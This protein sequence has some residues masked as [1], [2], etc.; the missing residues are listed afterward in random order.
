MWKRAEFL[1]GEFHTACHLASL[2]LD[3]GIHFVARFGRFQAKCFFWH[4]YIYVYIYLIDMC[5][6]P[7]ITLV[8][9]PCTREGGAGG[10]GF[11]FKR[12]I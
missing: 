6:I 9:R 7:V 4:K 8:L 10:R 11:P 5:F 12:V 3:F 2:N 1:S